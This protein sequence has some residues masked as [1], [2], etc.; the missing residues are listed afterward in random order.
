MGVSARQLGYYDEDDFFEA[1]SDKYDE[2][3]TSWGSFFVIFS[4]PFAGII[5]KLNP[6]CSNNSFR[7]GDAEANINSIFF[8]LYFYGIL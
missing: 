1:M 2:N 8:S 6:I 7:L 5:R 4:S 3:I